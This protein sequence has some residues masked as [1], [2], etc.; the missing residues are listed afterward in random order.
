MAGHLL[1]AGACRTGPPS[2]LPFVSSAAHLFLRYLE[3]ELERSTIGFDETYMEKGRTINERLPGLL[4]A[5]GIGLKA[6]SRS[7]L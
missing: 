5:N 1:P 4:Y 3:A 6:D 7:D 2:G